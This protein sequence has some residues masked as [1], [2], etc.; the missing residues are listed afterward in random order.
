[1]TRT[2]PRFLFKCRG[3]WRWVNSKTWIEVSANQ[4]GPGRGCVDVRV[5]ASLISGHAA[6]NRSNHLLVSALLVAF[7]AS[8]FF[9]AI[10]D[11]L[12]GAM[13]TFI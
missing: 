11:G 7:S 1:M 13:L 3:P 12:L 9:L 8:A 2:V 6:C 10:S 5:P 4:Q